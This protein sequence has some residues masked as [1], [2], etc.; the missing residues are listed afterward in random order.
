MAGRKHFGY[1][2]QCECLTS[3]TYAIRPKPMIPAPPPESAW[4]RF[5]LKMGMTPKGYKPWI[6]PP[7]SGDAEPA[8]RLLPEQAHAFRCRGCTTPLREWLHGDPCPKCG[9]GMTS[10]PGSWLIID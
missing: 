7:D 8:D 5:L 1:C 2:P 3:V 6:E 4:S 9:G 10:K